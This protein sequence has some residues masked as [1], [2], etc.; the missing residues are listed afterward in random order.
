M[1]TPSRV[2]PPRRRL[3]VDARRAM[4]LELGLKLFGARGLDDVSVE[5]IAREAGVS[6][7]LLYHYFGSKKEFHHEVTAHALAR[8]T[9]VTEPDRS[10]PPGERVVTGLV[11]YLEYLRADTTGWS[12]LL[13]GGGSGDERMWAIGE[14]YRRSIE[15]WVFEALP[16]GARTPATRVAVRGWIGSNTEMSLAWLDAGEPAL[17]DVVRLMVAVLVAVLDAAGVDPA[18]LAALRRDAVRTLAAVTD[19][20]SKRPDGHARAGDERH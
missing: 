13:R 18:V 10:R 2:A 4:L 11:A 14:A 12:W 5:D 16:K 20:G 19:A 3:T 6:A 7:G 17:A 1:S 9:A 15:D 8:L